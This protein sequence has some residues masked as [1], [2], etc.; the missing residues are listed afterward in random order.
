MEGV[1]KSLPL[2]V[3][4]SSHYGILPTYILTSLVSCTNL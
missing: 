3:C 4:V 2:C 1:Y